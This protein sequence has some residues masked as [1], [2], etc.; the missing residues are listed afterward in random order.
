M[1]FHTNYNKVLTIESLKSKGHINVYFML[2]NINYDFN[3]IIFA[4]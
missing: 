2:R 3:I 4:C 1:I